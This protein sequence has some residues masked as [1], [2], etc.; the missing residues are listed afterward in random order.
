LEYQ[1]IHDDYIKAYNI[2]QINRVEDINLGTELRFR[3]GYTSSEFEAYDSAYIVDAEYTKGFSLSQR[4]LVLTDFTADGFYRDGKFYSGKVK[5]VASYHWQN[6]KRGQFFVELTA[7]R[8]FHMFEEMPLELGGDTGLRGYPARYQAGDHL[9]LF[10]VEQRYFGEKEWLSLFYLGAAVFYDE[11]RAW[12][13][14]AIPQSQQGRLRDVGI[15]L[16]ISGTRTGNS[17][18]GEHNIVH[19]DVAYP[20]DAEGDKDISKVQWLVRVK[21]KF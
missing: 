1:H 17:E 5:G 11:G 12:G 10:T 4:Q 9:Q 21:K 20:L 3:L 16:R 2:Q 7:A 13:E 8:G 6:F 18:G 15:G 14:S 19:F